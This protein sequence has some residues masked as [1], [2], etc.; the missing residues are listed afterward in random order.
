M[1]KENADTEKKTFY[2]IGLDTE[3][4]KNHATADRRTPPLERV[5]SDFVK[6]FTERGSSD[7]TLSCVDVSIIK[8]DALG[9][10]I[11]DT[12]D[13]SLAGLNAKPSASKTPP[14]IETR[15]PGKLVS[16]KLRPASG[17]SPPIAIDQNRTLFLFAL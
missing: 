14:K 17:E 13:W 12:R 3:G 4:L 8:K 16:G 2:L 9:D 1:E 6:G 10:I 5:C 7:P 15:S 11:C